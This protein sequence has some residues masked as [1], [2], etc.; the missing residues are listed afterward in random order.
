MV[1]GNCCSCDGV[2]RTVAILVIQFWFQASEWHGCW[3]AIFR[4]VFNASSSHASSSSHYL[5]W[6]QTLRHHHTIL[7]GES[8][9]QLAFTSLLLFFRA[10]P[11]PEAV[12]HGPQ[13]PWMEPPPS[14]ISHLPPTQQ[15][16]INRKRLQ[17]LEFLKDLKDW[18]S[19]EDDETWYQM[20]LGFAIIVL[21]LIW[22]WK[23]WLWIL[24]LLV[25]LLDL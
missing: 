20:P 15:I 10:M 3:H 5:K 19:N 17:Q 25:W 8:D 9:I 16:A 13:R 23:T 21:I 4:I 24:D 12:K 6:N 1:W 22:N 7:N 18:D 2:A 11:I 14:L